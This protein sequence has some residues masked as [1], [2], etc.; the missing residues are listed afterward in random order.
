MLPTRHS[1]G[2]ETQFYLPGFEA[3][4]A[5]ITCAAILIRQVG[6]GSLFITALATCPNACCFLGPPVY[7]L[8]VFSDGT[9]QIMNVYSIYIGVRV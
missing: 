2:R 8:V 1:Q 6:I 4:M 7:C 5:K 9:V 3:P